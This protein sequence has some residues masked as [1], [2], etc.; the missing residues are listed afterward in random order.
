MNRVQRNPFFAYPYSGMNDTL[1]QGPISTEEAI[2]QN[3]ANREARIQ[4]LL[5][6]G[7]SFW[8]PVSLAIGTT[9][10]AGTTFNFVTT[11]VDF[12][13]LLV[14]AWSSLSLSQI[15]LKDSARNRLLT[16]GPTQIAAIAGF[17]DSSKTAS[18]LYGWRKPY[19]LPARAQISLT[20]TA[21]GTES[22]GN[23]AF[24]CLQPPAYNG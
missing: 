1:P 3:I 15:E 9:P 4:Y 20:V 11:V 24:I 8:L 5:E 22:T 21:N 14:D 7:E 13:L 19:L 18:R 10:A 17:T 6:H 16:N 23:W 2:G 12:D